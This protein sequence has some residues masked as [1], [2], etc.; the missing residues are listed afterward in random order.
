MLIVITNSVIMDLVIKT[1]KL[2]C[3]LC[4]IKKTLGTCNYYH[5]L[6]TWYIDFIRALS[7]GETL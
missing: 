7:N 4:Q 3:V 1:W 6:Y 2:D 5:T